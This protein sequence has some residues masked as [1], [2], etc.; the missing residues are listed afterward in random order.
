[1]GFLKRL[2]TI[3]KRNKRDRE[4][5]NDNHRPPITDFDP[6]TTLHLPK[7]NGDSEAAFSR[8]L[9]SSS[10][11][12]NVV[13]EVDYNL[14]PPI[15]HPINTV[16]SLSTTTLSPSRTSS[17]GTKNSYTVKIHQRQH[18]ASTVFPNAYPPR[19]PHRIQQRSTPNLLET[20]NHRSRRRQV[21]DPRKVP[22]TPRD[23][24]R[25]SRLRQ[26]PSVASLLNMYDDNGQLD[27][28]A[29]ANTPARVQ[30]ACTANQCREST[31]KELL[32]GESA[33][34]ADLSWAE[35]CIAEING[36]TSTLSTV[37][38]PFFPQTPPAP[39]CRELNDE[40]ANNGLLSDT[41]ETH[42]AISSMTVELSVSTNG[43]GPILRN[44]TGSTGTT[45][46][47]LKTPCRINRTPSQR[48]SQVFN[49]LS[50]KR[51]Q[52]RRSLSSEEILDAI[53]A[54]ERF[55]SSI[56]EEP[57][58]KISVECTSAPAFDI[59]EIATNEYQTAEYAVHPR[60]ASRLAALPLPAPAPPS[61]VVFRPL[62]PA[63]RGKGRS[64]GATDILRVKESTDAYSEARATQIP[65]KG[66]TGE[67]VRLRAERERERRRD[68][69]SEE[70]AT[71]Y[72]SIS[73]TKMPHVSRKL[74][75]VKG[76]RRK[77][78][79]R[80]AFGERTNGRADVVSL[81]QDVRTAMATPSAPCKDS[82][83]NPSVSAVKNHSSYDRHYK[84]FVA[85]LGKE[86]G[87]RSG[88][89]SLDLARAATT[90][91]FAASSKTPLPAHSHP[92]T[93]TR[94][95]S[96][97]DPPSPVS[98]SE[99]SPQAQQLMADLRKRKAHIHRAQRIQEKHTRAHC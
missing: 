46:A 28:T 26:D 33:F 24:S 68:W 82:K 53:T 27:D 96:L 34:E 21:S 2:F 71:H 58:K 9:R 65:A 73:R 93:P 47:E 62:N 81:E 48:A 74:P 92:L 98:S 90:Q 20:V 63:P 61:P 72:A 13:S 31:F 56:E 57:I 17:V 79:S 50:E 22:I 89:K 59:H 86:N 35:H 88:K 25:L 85:E 4:Q 12:F 87:R 19:T 80:P 3:G 51:R 55:S 60:P 49:F 11:H 5:S 83:V 91:R 66:P 29:F 38:S 76:P 40:T 8:L 32:G 18:H 78:S 14:L 44:W 75:A 43:D 70:T 30:S 39:A 45:E 15:S 67:H 42:P 10:A 97:S 52:R 1:M 64:T 23:I 37:S 16:S 95:R 7:L 99:L 77:E 84:A 41:S 36:S 69:E 54:V 6:D 94:G